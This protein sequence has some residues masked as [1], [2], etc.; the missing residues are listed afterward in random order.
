MKSF[1][2]DA[3]KFGLSTDSSRSEF[4]WGKI[5]KSFLL[6]FLVAATSYLV[7]AVVGQVFTLDARYWVFSIKTMSLERCVLFLKYLPFFFIYSLGNSLV[8]QGQFRLPEMGSKTTL[9]WTLYYMFFNL[10]GIALMLGLQY[11]TL[12]VNEIMYMPEEALFSI[13]GIGHLLTL[14]VTAYFSTYFFRKTGSIYTGA[15][16]NA[17]FLTW[18]TIANQAILWPKMLP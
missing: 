12:F 7:L 8:L 4:D 3:Y 10:F 17:M 18:Y 9:I 13:L 16:Y 11:G 15:F 2:T 1:I 5:G 6:S 14:S